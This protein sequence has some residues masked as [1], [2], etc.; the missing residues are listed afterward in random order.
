[1]LPH[2]HRAPARREVSVRAPPCTAMMTA[3]VAMTKAMIH[4]MSARLQGTQA[5]SDRFGGAQAVSAAQAHLFSLEVTYRVSIWPAAVSRTPR[6][7][8]TAA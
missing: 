6:G 8:S 1:M 7:N 3:L 2:F 5:R 4:T